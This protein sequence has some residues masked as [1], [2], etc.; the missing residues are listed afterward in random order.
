M[1]RQSTGTARKSARRVRVVF[2]I[3][4]VLMSKHIFTTLNYRQKSEAYIKQYMHQPLQDRLIE[5]HRELT[6]K[7]SD[8]TLAKKAQASLSW[9]GDVKTTI[10]H[11]RFLGAQHRPDFKIEIE[12]MQIAV[13]IKRGEAGAA[14][15]EGIGQSLVYACSTD[16]DFVIYLLVDTSKDKKILKSLESDVEEGFVES[17]W[18]NYNVRFRV[19]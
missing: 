19:V 3:L 6:P 11:V 1:T 18:Q 10:N 7:V 13:E 17:L 4:D 5:V 9:E 2:Q 8:A 16:Y 15:R 14:V 12:D